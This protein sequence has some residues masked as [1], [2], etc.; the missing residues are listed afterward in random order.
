MHDNNSMQFIELLYK[1]IKLIFTVNT[2]Y[3]EITES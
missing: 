3:L 2:H 1:I